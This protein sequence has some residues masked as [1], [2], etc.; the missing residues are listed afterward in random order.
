MKGKTVSPKKQ[1]KI[2]KKEYSKELLNIAEGDLKTAIAIMKD[3]DARIENAFYMVQQCIEK[4]LK[5]I[6]IQNGLPV[7]LVHDLGVLLGKLPDEI[8]PPFG[9]E[10]TDLNQYASVR[11]YENGKFDLTKEEIELVIEKGKE[12]YRWSLDQIK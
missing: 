5:A 4:S 2:F 1:E 10:L 11:R 7:P 9:Y 6:L 3:P 8:V 12:F